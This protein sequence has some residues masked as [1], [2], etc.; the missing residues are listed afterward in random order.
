[1]TKWSSYWELRIELNEHSSVHA[2][3][4]SRFPKAR[5][6]EIVILDGMRYRARYAPKFSRSYKTIHS[7]ER[8]WECLGPVDAN[9]PPADEDTQDESGAA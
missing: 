4:E 7:W 5:S 1:M 9:V 8:W 6:G 3:L 2:R